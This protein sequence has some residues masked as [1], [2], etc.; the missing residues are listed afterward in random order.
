MKLPSLTSCETSFLSPFSDAAGVSPTAATS[1]R[2]GESGQQSQPGTFHDKGEPEA[3]KA[4]NAEPNY[5]DCHSTAVF[6][7][8]ESAKP[9]LVCQD[10]PVRYEN[11]LTMKGDLLPWP[12]AMR[13]NAN[14]Y[15][16]LT[17]SQ[18]RMSK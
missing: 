17:V 16:D 11:F 3:Q 12:T 5:W 18:C 15:S 4:T 2:S 8:K 9:L 13:S 6:G 7:P 14:I 10:Q 1:V